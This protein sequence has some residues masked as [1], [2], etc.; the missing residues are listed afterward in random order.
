MKVFTA[1]QMRAFDK[2]A[3]EE[4]GMPSIVLME[5]AALRVV[6]FLEAKFSPLE[7]K[8]I[9][10]L[11]G[12]GNNGAD[13][14]AIA[15]HLYR[16]MALKRVHVI[17]GPEEMYHGD[18]LTNHRAW[19]LGDKFMWEGAEEE[20]YSSALL[21]SQYWPALDP[22]N[23]PK[24]ADFK[25]Y[26]FHGASVLG[27]A[28]IVVDC[29]LGTGTKGELRHPANKLVEWLYHHCSQAAHVFVDLPSGLSS[30]EGAM[31][32]WESER[33]DDEVPWS[34][35][36][37]F[38]S[39]HTVTFVGPKRG[40]FLKDGPATCGEIWVGSIGTADRMLED[41]ET[42]CETLDLLTIQD[43]L[44]RREMDAHKGDA[45]R[46]LILGGSFGMSGSIALA[47]RAALKVGVG[48]CIAALPEKALPLFAGACLEATSH[49]LPGDDQGRL[50]PEAADGLPELWQNVQAVALG[51]G[52]SRSEGA[53]E[54]ARR[55]VR[56]C[57]QPLI[58]DADALYALPAIA[59]E[60]KAREAATILTP[61]PGE[62]GE[63]MG[64]N[65]KEVNDDRYGIAAACAAKYGAMVV[66]KGAHSL[67]ATPEG[68]IFVN[69]TGNPGMATG[70]S[71]DA[72]T[73]TIAGLLAQ[74]KDAEQA[75]KVGVYLHGYAGDIAFRTLGNGL[76]AGDI[77]DNLPAALLE[78]AQRQPERINGRL[79]RLQ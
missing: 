25:D 77:V 2:A 60:V 58:I 26:Y 16:Y 37:Q 9:V 15:R 8:W 6:E 18:A 43:Y 17:L 73:G 13:G 40:F 38:P 7:E 20:P 46:S 63:L 12:K 55:V 39:S 14:L 33:H 49:A 35:Q 74:L 62:M 67:V 76:V 69:L 71:G 4:W 48:L 29:I 57:P 1:E 45:G 61:H 36:C 30:D 47:A 44:P 32:K 5:N 52:L 11:C 28:D 51:P 54:F 41:T 59:D 19:T 27:H 68:R 72:L 23:K 78:V 75:T 10:I 79:V 53:L 65:A 42:N 22:A 34:W 31:A 66:L 64:I 21:S 56:E 3:T 70:G 24:D 50:L